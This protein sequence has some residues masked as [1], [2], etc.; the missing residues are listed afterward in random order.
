MSSTLLFS[1]RTIEETAAVAA[2]RDAAQ[3]KYTRFE[4]AWEGW[5]WVIA[6]GPDNAYAVPGF[7]NFYLFKSHPFYSTYGIP[8]TTITYELLN[9]DVVRI[10]GILVA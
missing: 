9:A 8:P 10:I 5:T 1:A 3:K 4:E 6:R 7:P 2:D